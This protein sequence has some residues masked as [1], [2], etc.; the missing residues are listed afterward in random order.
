MQQLLGKLNDAIKE[1]RTMIPCGL[2]LAACWTH[3]STHKC[4]WRQYGALVHYSKT[5]PL[6][7]LI[8]LANNIQIPSSTVTWSHVVSFLQMGCNLQGHITV[9]SAVVSLLCK[10]R[11]WVTLIF[12]LKS[13]LLLCVFLFHFNYVFNVNHDISS[14]SS[15]FLLFYSLLHFSLLPCL[16]CLV[17]LLPSLMPSTYCIPTSLLHTPP[18]S[19]IHLPFCHNSH[20]LTRHFAC[21]LPSSII[22]SL[23]FSSVSAPVW[24]RCVCRT[25]Y[26]L[27]ST[28]SGMERR[29]GRGEFLTTC[30]F[31]YLKIIICQS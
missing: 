28:S 27:S 25:V 13:K 10:M 3:I 24:L 15:I 2:L 26:P 16:I 6:M 18:P 5:Y 1:K 7:C 30:G 14:P 21:H 12:F 29:S 22:H 9:L 31:M 8:E 23:P 17:S 20:F 11:K 4:F 19:L